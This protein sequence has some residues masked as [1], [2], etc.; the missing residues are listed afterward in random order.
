MS[1][2]SSVS[3][4]RV[5]NPAGKPIL[6]LKFGGTSVGKFIQNICGQIIPNLLKTHR[7]IVVCSARSTD[8]KAKGTTTRLVKAADA[9]LGDE[10]VDHQQIVQDILDDH[11]EAT[12]ENITNPDIRDQLEKSL[13]KVCHRLK[14]FLEAAEVI[15]EVSPKSKDIIIGTGEKL[16]CEYVAS[17]LQDKG[18]DATY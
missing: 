3:L 18:V 8:V 9:V 6:V 15:N 14:V 13:T 2:S 17:V 16:A 5:E 7:V 4:P 11:I 1:P 10:S 12:R